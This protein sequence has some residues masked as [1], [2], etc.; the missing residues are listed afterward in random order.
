MRDG[1]P[2]ISISPE[3]DTFVAAGAPTTNFGTPDYADTYGGQNPSCV[4]ASA[5]AYTLMRFDLS[6]IP[7]GAEISHVELDT[8]TRA[9]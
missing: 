2:S 1:D 9:G 6:A 7:L 4:L 5:P 8:T 3:A